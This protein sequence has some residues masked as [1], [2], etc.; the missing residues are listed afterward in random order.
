MITRTM[1][2]VML[3]KEIQT[4]IIENI[5]PYLKRN[6]DNKI[7]RAIVKSTHLPMIFNPIHYFSKKTHNDWYIFYYA[8][9]KKC[10]DDAACLAISLVQSEEGAYVYEQVVSGNPNDPI[11]IFP[12]HFFSRYH[13]RF[14]K[15]ELISKM[16]LITHY[17]KNNYIG[18]ITAGTMWGNRCA[19]ST[20]NG[21]AFGEVLDFEERLFIF[22]TYITKDLIRKNQTFAK[23]F[24]QIEE[25]NMLKEFMNMK[26]PDK[27]LLESFDFYLNAKF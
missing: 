8:T 5:L 12:P 6:Y 20:T 14:L 3:R 10:A 19:M 27:Y 26:D 16:D 13:S 4:D 7:R 9:S 25:Q 11:Y 15:D 24:N 2:P 18:L 23:A 22:K 21:Y 1:S 17:F